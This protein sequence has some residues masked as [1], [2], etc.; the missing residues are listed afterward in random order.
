MLLI[1]HISLPYWDN[2][3][4]LKFPTVENYVYFL[5]FSTLRYNFITVLLNINLVYFIINNNFIQNVN[6]NSIYWDYE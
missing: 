2:K 5:L 3:Y 1:C 4:K 6:T